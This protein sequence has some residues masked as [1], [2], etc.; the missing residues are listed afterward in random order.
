[1]T[2]V[3]VA[4]DHSHYVATIGPSLKKPSK[5]TL[6]LRK[7]FEMERANTFT[8]EDSSVLWELADSCVSP[9]DVGKEEGKTTATHSKVSMPRYWKRNGKRELRII[10]RNDCY[11]IVAAALL[12][13]AF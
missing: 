3:A 9:K 11:R 6:N 10:V 4:V 7:V 13:Q 2:Q 8:V 12:K 1:L 5:N